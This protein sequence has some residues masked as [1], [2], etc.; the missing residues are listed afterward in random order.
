MTILAA[1]A[2]PHS[3]LKLFGPDPNTVTNATAIASTPGANNLFQL[4]CKNAKVPK[5]AIGGTN[6]V[7]A[8]F[9]VVEGGAYTTNDTNSTYGYRGDTRL[10]FAIKNTDGKIVASC[11]YDLASGNLDRVEVNA[12][13]GI[14]TYNALDPAGNTKSVAAVTKAKAPFALPPSLGA[15][16]YK[17]SIPV[18]FSMHVDTTT[19]ANSYIRL[20]MYGKVV[21]EITGALVH[22]STNMNLGELSI[23]EFITSSNY[24]SQTNN[25]NYYTSARMSYLVVSDVID[26]SLKAFAMKPSA[27]G[28]TN[29]FTG[30]ISALTPWVQDKNYIA[31][32]TEIGATVDIKLTITA[33]HGTATQGLS[34]NNMDVKKLQLFGMFRYV[35]AGGTTVTFGVTLMV[36]T[37]AASAQ[38]KIVIA[39][40]ESDDNYLNRKIGE[41]VT[42]LINSGNF[43]ITDLNNL[44]ARITLVGV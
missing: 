44:Y 18:A 21:A 12:C 13:I 7:I 29:D 27:F 39:A 20:T 23:T 38:Q 25:S 41:V 1:A 36:G 33:T 37:T 24:S 28:T 31:S 30:P 35:Q 19:P 17:C 8:K 14:F 16:Y 5:L 40:N 42:S 4:Y 10:L 11:G 3:W 9:E 26:N 6:E 2:D 32:A 22:S 34:A 43:S 15:V